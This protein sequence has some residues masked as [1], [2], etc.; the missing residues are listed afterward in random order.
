M[1]VFNHST[2]EWTGMV[3]WIMELTISLHSVRAQKGLFYHRYIRVQCWINQ[4]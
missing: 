2:G 1:G 4:L 3:E